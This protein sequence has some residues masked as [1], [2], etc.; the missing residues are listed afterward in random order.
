M[1][2]EKI[3]ILA[4]PMIYTLAIITFIISIYLIEKVVNNRMFK[5]ID[6]QTQ[7]V[8]EEIVNINEYIPVVNID[9]SILKPFLGENIVVNKKFYDHNST[10]SQEDA[11]I[12][13]EGTYMQNTGIDY[14]SENS[15]DIVSILDGTVINVENNEILGNTIEIRHDNDLISLYQCVDD[16]QVKLDDIVLRGQK[17][18]TSGTCNLYNKGNN[19]H[20]ELYHNGLIVNPIEYYD[21]DVNDIQ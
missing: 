8:D 19:I 20:F 6:E 3:K 7:Y 5:D 15:F 16:L 18:A 4:V 9:T 11:I 13:Y 2:K 21:K 12:Y 1:K 14:N 17:I 10:D